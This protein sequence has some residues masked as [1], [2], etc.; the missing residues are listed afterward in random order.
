MVWRMPQSRIFWD[1]KIWGLEEQ[2]ILGL[3]GRKCN[4]LYWKGECHREKYFGIGRAEY[5]GVGREKRAEQKRK[6]GE[7][8]SGVEWRGEE[9]AEECRR[10]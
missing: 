4:I 3:E 9:K 7:E 8:C 2:N 1:W 6:K 10:E 5:F